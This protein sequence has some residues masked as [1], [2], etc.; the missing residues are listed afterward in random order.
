M[1]SFAAGSSGDFLGGFYSD[2]V[3]REIGQFP[4]HKEQTYRVEFTIRGNARE[5]DS[6]YPKLLTETQPWEREGPVIGSA[7]KPLLR[8]VVC[9]VLLAAGGILLLTPFLR[10]LRRWW[11]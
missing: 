5:L 2:V 6:T 3:A 10:K 11:S 8:T 7:V 1:D 9:S 4:G